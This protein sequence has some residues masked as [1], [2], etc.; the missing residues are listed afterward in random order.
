MPCAKPFLTA[1]AALA[2]AA[3]TTRV[4]ACGARLLAALEVVDAVE[5]VA[6]EFGDGAAEAFIGQ[7]LGGRARQGQR[8]RGDARARGGA[9]GGGDRA[10]P[11]LARELVLRRLALGAEAD[12]QHAFGADAFEVGDQPGF[13]GLAGEVTALDEPREL[14][15]AAQVEGLGFGGEF[16][17][18]VDADGDTIDGQLGERLRPDFELHCSRSHCRGGRRCFKVAKCNSSPFG[19]SV[20]ANS[21]SLHPARSRRQLVR[22]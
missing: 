12:Q 17:V 11:G 20:A 3:T 9:D 22:Q 18:I 13:A 4:S 16:A 15:A 2:G 8:Q 21:R 19:W 7:Q 10:A 6:G 1:C 14:F 5:R